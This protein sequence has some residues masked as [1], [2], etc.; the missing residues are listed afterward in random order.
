L[1]DDGL[2]PRISEAFSWIAELRLIAALP[3]VFDSNH[4]SKIGRTLPDKIQNPHHE[5]RNKQRAGV[6]KGHKGKS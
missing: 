5:P 1:L 4:V 6:T 2:L 3:S